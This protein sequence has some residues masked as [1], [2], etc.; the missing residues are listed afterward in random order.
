MPRRRGPRPPSAARES[1]RSACSGLERRG[2]PAAATVAAEPR[3]DALPDYFAFAARLRAPTD[4]VRER[5]RPYVDDL[6]R[7]A[8][9]LD[10]VCGRGELLAL[11]RGH[12]IEARSVDAN[13]DMVAFA[14]GEGLEVAQAD[15]FETL[16]H[17]DTRLNEHVF[18][19]L[20][21]ALIAGA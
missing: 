14:R 20:D 9:V 5:Q 16:R 2:T 19:P 21:Y 1:S 17:A 7:H 18:A 13:A 6:R 12:G 4:E 11:L 8:P 3:Q 10:V 15:L